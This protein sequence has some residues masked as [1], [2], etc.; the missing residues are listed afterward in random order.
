MGDG[1]DREKLQNLAGPTIT[2]LGHRSD[3]DEKYE[4]LRRAK[5]L[6]NITK[7]SCGIVTMEALALGV[8]V[9]GYN[10]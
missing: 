9:F 6:I 5:G 3:P 2:F 7:E 10:A 4:L 1:P 8:P